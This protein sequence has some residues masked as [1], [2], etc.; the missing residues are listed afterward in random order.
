M[1]NR[2]TERIDFLQRCK[3][4]QVLQACVQTNAVR[5]R[6]MPISVFATNVKC[7][8]V[9]I[10]KN[11]VRKSHAIQST[12]NYICLAVQCLPPHFAQFHRS[13]N[14]MLVSLQIIFIDLHL[15]SNLA[16]N[17]INSV[18]IKY[19]L[20]NE[21]CHFR[22]SWDMKRCGNICFISK[23]V[24]YSVSPVKAEHTFIPAASG[25]WASAP[26]ASRWG[27]GHIV[28]PLYFCDDIVAT[29]RD[30]EAKLCTHLPE[31]L[32]EV[33]SKFCIDPI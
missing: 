6:Y 4:E 22:A 17:P 27:G 25:R 28:A 31:Y 21:I 20:S 10:M 26:P 29:R 16:L 7:N 18:C 11:D 32:A 12:R 24:T 13:S 23:S 3:E 5:I 33:V 2:T 14:A 9:F 19:L 15:Y 8:Y 30:R 1:L